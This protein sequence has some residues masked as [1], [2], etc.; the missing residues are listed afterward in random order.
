MREVNL[1]HVILPVSGKSSGLRSMC[2]R[3]IT[4]TGL[5]RMRSM[6]SDA[7]AGGLGRQEEAGARGPGCHAMHDVFIQSTNIPG[8]VPSNVNKTIQRN[9]L[10]SGAHV[11]VECGCHS[12]GDAESAVCSQ[13]SP[14][15]CSAVTHALWWIT[16]YRCRC[17]S[18][19]SVL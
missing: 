6:F 18:P 16:L 17:V 4:F 13:T 2:R 8:A 12:G 11:P 1:P 19:H 5:E 9:S 7:H 10:L 14:F 3:D 15:L